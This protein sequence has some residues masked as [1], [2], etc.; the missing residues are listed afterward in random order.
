MTVM[1]EVEPTQ[2]TD[3][4]TTPP[5][6]N[7]SCCWNKSAWRMDPRNSYS[8]WKIEISVLTS[9][10]LHTDVS[11]INFQVHKF[12]LAVGPRKS[13]YFD[14]LFRSQMKESKAGKTRITL[15]PSAA[16]AFPV[17]LD[18]I[19]TGDLDLN[20][21]SAVALGYLGDYFGVAKLL[22]LVDAFIQKDI[23]QTQANVHVYCEE[24][25][26]YKN[27]KL[28]ET[29]MTAVATLSQDELLQAAANHGDSVKY[30]A[31]PV[32]EMMSLLSLEQRNQVYLEAL[33]VAHAE[34]ARLKPVKDFHT[35]VFS[36]VAFRPE[37]IPALFECLKR[38]G[39][40][41]STHGQTWMPI[42]YYDGRA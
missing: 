8:D 41:R 42:F 19:Y 1:E 26:V 33:R 22:P 23:Q 34:M 36:N 35:G 20:P 40:I 15:E 16:K 31:T 7:T 29:L 10:S 6:M 32:E 11:P 14:S 5:A 28:V 25:I 30:D 37:L 13:L 24:A 39:A 21:S 27:S 18:Y 3:G 12:F 9:A 17:F 2:E 4:T 38:G